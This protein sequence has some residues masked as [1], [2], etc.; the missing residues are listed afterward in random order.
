MLCEIL[1]RRKYFLGKFQAATCKKKKKKSR[2]HI[3]NITTSGM[4]STEIKSLPLVHLGEELVKDKINASKRSG[5][6]NQRQRTAI[7]RVHLFMA[8]QDQ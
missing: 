8:L 2:M 5:F 3:I 7:Q 4:E 1:G 6:A